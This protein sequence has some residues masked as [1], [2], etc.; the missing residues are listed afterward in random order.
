MRRCAFCQDGLPASGAKQYR[1]ELLC[2][3]CAKIALATHG[4]KKPTSAV[5]ARAAE[6]DTYSMS[7]NRIALVSIGSLVL[8]AASVIGS[9][10]VYQGTRDT[11][12]RDNADAVLSIR[13]TIR[14]TI[15]IVD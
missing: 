6:I 7:N 10:L 2:A 13:K 9:I 4:S 11:W 12:E 14:Y 1:S 15:C 3:E 8:V 5:A